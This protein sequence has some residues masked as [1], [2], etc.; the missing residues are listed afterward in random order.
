MYK[1]ILTEALDIPTYNKKNRKIEKPEDAEKQI[2]E[3]V[4]KGLATIGINVTDDDADTVLAVETLVPFVGLEDIITP[5]PVK[6][7]HPVIE[8]FPPKPYGH[9]Q[10]RMDICNN[11]Y[12]LFKSDEKW[13]SLGDQYKNPLY[14][15]KGVIVEPNNMG[16]PTL[17]VVYKNC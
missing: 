4:K 16:K 2:Y 12:G 14:Q 13:V 15:L 10:S 1:T 9:G 6:S 5:H 8:P 7:E 11:L 3:A 17:K